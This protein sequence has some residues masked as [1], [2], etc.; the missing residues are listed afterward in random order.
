MDG[1]VPALQ[2][3]QQGLWI[4]YRRRC[5]RS[6]QDAEGWR[7]C[8]GLLDQIKDQTAAARWSESVIHHLCLAGETRRGEMKTGAA[9]MSHQQPQQRAAPVRPRLDG[10]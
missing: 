9:T 4:T 2:P 8:R 10:S 1:F 5:V 3:Q 7:Q 6:A